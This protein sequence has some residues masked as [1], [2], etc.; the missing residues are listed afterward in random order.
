MKIMINSQNS[1][2][3]PYNF[4]HSITINMDVEVAN[5]E[6]LRAFSDYLHGFNP[7]HL[8][9]SKNPVNLVG[10]VIEKPYK[11]KFKDDMVDSLSLALFSMKQMEIKPLPIPN[12]PKFPNITYT[13]A[14]VAPEISV[15]IDTL[16]IE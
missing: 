11:K 7:Y 10:E 1:Q 2:Y 15:V 6:E 3:D 16:E 12:D 13:P 8:V 9:P 5:E 4:G 14:T